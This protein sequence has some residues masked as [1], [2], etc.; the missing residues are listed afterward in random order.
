MRLKRLFFTEFGRDVSPL[1][2]QLQLKV[3]FPLVTCAKPRSSRALSLESFVVCQNYQPPDGYR[4]IYFKSSFRIDALETE[5]VTSKN[6]YDELE[7]LSVQRQK[8]L[9]ATISA[10]PEEVQELRLLLSE[11][12][13]H[14]PRHRRRDQRN[15]RSHQVRW[16][17]LPSTIGYLLLLLLPLLSPPSQ[18]QRTPFPD[19]GDRIVV[20]R[21]IKRLAGWTTRMPPTPG[22]IVGSSCKCLKSCHCYRRWSTG[23]NEHRINELGLELGWKVQGWK[24]LGAKPPTPSKTR[25]SSSD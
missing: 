21:T 24:S 7:K 3:F 12:E 6:N 22:T 15:L 19:S 14:L 9:L 20:P 2:A 13:E 4:P 8:G 18:T 1:Y 17:I 5:L 23:T 11:K 25:S 10:L 16:M